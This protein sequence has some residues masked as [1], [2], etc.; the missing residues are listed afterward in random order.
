L[1]LVELMGHLSM[2]YRRQA[3]TPRHRPV[4]LPDAPGCPI[5][6]E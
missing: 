4:A 6:S 5:R 3:L 1:L 2:A